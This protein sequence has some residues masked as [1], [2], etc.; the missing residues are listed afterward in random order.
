MDMRYHAQFMNN[1]EKYLISKA[2]GYGFFSDLMVSLGHL[3]L[4]ELTQRTPIVYWGQN[5]LFRSATTQNAFTEYFLPCSDAELVTVCR[6]ELTF[7]PAK[8]DYQNLEKEDFGKWVGPHARM[9]GRDFLDH[10]EDVLVCDFY[11][12]IA[13]LTDQLPPSSPYLKKDLTQGYHRL[14]ARHITPKPEINAQATALHDR[15]VGN[16][17]ALAV[18]F[19]GTDKAGEITN[20]TL[21]QLLE[22]YLVATKQVLNATHYDRIY[23]MTDDKRAL[24]S[25]RQAFGDQLVYTDIDRL[26]ENIGVHYQDPG[27]ERGMEVLLDALIAMRC[28]AFI[29]NGFSNLSCFIHAARNWRG[30]SYLLGGN[31]MNL[32]NEYIY[33]IDSSGAP[34]Q[35]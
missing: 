34:N 22:H 8:W 30:H 6:P 32:K 31:L 13:E 23:L 25:F 7:F 19:R 27:I 11:T 18:H 14:I 12:A 2:W 4:A 5:S 1:N 29:G 21:K 16:N 28:N 9:H 24:A 26:S 20:I 10:D 33:Q 3:L 17:T 15:L 35:Q